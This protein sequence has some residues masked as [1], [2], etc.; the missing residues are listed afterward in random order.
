[1]IE[2]ELLMYLIKNP[3]EGQPKNKDLIYGVYG[4]EKLYSDVYNNV[5]SLKNRILENIPY[6][7]Y[8]EEYKNCKKEPGWPVNQPVFE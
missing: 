3:L 8:G 1:M 2:M 6:K 4:R 7:L 5:E